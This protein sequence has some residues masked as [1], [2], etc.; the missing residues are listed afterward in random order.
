VNRVLMVEDDMPLRRALRANLLAGGVEVLEA[1][2]GEE[3]LIVLWSDQP[4]MVILDLQLPGIDGLETLRHLRGFSKVPVV[5]LTVRD[6]LRDKVAALDAGADD[7][8]TKPFETDELLARVRAHL[9]RSGKDGS[10]SAQIRA[11]DLEIDMPH[12]Q[13]T[14]Q[15]DRVALTT[16]EMHLLE[17][18][19]ANRGRLMTHDELLAAVWDTRPA[20]AHSRL[21][22]AI[23][24]LRRKIHDDAARPR[25]IFTE[26]GLGYRWIGEGEQL[27]DER[28][29][30]APP[31]AP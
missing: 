16:M 4:D 30:D 31:H 20:S 17:T 29:E 13:V 21:R 22:V 14:W 10:V 3:A 26:P 5:V 28:S 7:Y 18:L 12:R 9:R 15:G 19:V 2:T 11:G 27:V 23:L 25:L 24:H 6:T 8:V 1:A